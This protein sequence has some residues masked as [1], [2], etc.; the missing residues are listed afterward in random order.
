MAVAPM[1]WKRLLSRERLGRPGTATPDLTRTDFQ[2]DFDRI[3]FSSAFRRLQDKTQVF[4]LAQNDYVR[5]RLTHSLEVAS[6]GRTLGTRVG[7]RIIVEYRLTDVQAADFGAIVAAACLA[8]DIGNPPFGHAGEDAIRDWF[9][10]SV[11]GQA[12]LTLLRPVERADLLRFEGNAQG[13]R[14]LTRL[15]SAAN[16][17]GLQLTYATLGA[18]SKYPCAVALSH[19]R[20]QGSAWRKFGFF[21]ADREHFEELAERL[22]LIA[23]AADAW[24]RH[25]LAWLVEAADDICYCIVD[26]EDA[27]RL[28]QLDYRTAVDLLSP[29][30]ES[31]HLAARL[32]AIPTPKERIE[33]LRAKAIG[34]LIDQ[35]VECFLSHEEA[36]LAGEF[37]SELLMHIALTPALTA[38]RKR[39]AAEIYV[40]PSV[41]EIGAA[42]FH[43]LATLLDTFVAAVNAVAEHGSAA[44]PRQH[45]LLRLV[46]E[47]FIGAGR[48]PAPDPYRRLLGITDFVSGMTDSYA[49]ALY[50]K[51]HGISLPTL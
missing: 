9:N 11:T 36:I 51:L 41:V 25:P 39:A 28:R 4:P 16:A 30:V 35:T 34:V 18:F 20:P 49:V 24:Q 33:Y 13:F 17:G 8:H 48:Q 46:P 7:E 21:Q 37:D 40:A 1:C 22:G 15:Q 26:I 32:A 23:V 6:V 5:T 14:V 10:S 12:A 31:G 42:G 43:V 38:L 2:R 47:Q 3:V 27:Y 19:P 50:K 45:M 29:L 44:A